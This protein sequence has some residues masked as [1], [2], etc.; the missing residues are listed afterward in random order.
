MFAENIAIGRYVEK[1]SLMHS[2]DPRAKLI[3]LFFL[4]GF[5]FTINSFY[6]VALMSFYTLLLMLLSKVGLKTYW[7]SIKSMWMLILF[8]FVVQLFNYEGNVIYQ[9]WFIKITDTGLSNAAIITF[10]LFFAI[11]LSSVL[12]LTTS[13]TSLANAMEDVLIWFRVKRSFAHELS[14]V[15]TIAIRF[16][17]VMAR[18]AE[19][20]F[21]AQMSRGANFDSR[22]ISGRLKGLVAIIIPLLVSALRRADELSIAMEA[23]CYNG[24]E[25]RT[26]YKLFNWRFRD[27]LFFISFISLGITMII[28]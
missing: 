21:K 13:P 14:M 17:P 1:K 19:R 4:A 7:K 9:L 23:R 12:T 25:G 26:R 27:T 15:M 6:D 5:A 11:M 20:I 18:E 3:G 2:L 10:R 28:I 22:K 16:I 8:A 24:W